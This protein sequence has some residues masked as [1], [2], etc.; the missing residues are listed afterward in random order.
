M[1]F[2]WTTFK[3]TDIEKTLEFYK[4]TLGW[5]ATQRFKPSEDMEIVFLGQGETKLEFIQDPNAPTGGQQGVSLGFAVD[6]VEAKKAELEAAGF[7][8]TPIISPNPH[9]KYFFVT[10]P[11][12]IN[13]QFVEQA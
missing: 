3:V 10:D 13:I 9:V 7:K 12:G 1:K 5:E 4:A 8:A 2:L 6:S 11:N